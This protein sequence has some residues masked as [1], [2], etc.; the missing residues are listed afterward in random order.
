VITPDGR[1][2]SVPYFS[3]VHLLHYNAK[4]LEDNGIAGPPTTL[5]DLYSQCEQLKAAGIAAPYAAYWT[6]QFVEEYLIL[7]L[8]A[9]GIVPFDADGNP[10]FQDDPKTIDVF[11][12]WQSM[13]QDGLTSPTILTDDPGAHVIAMAQGNSSFFTLHHYF[14]N[15]VR[16]TDGPEAEN[17]T[18]AYTMPGANGQSLQIGEVVQLGTKD[19]GPRADQAWELLKFY[20]W[21]DA[22]GRYGTFIS[23]AQ[24]AALLAPYPGLFA[25][26]EFRAAFP[27]SYDLDALSSAFE[28]SQVVPARV[29]PWYASFQTKVGDRIH[30]LLLGDAS[31]EETASRLADDAKEFAENEG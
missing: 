28:A 23:W 5:S 31:P 10:V 26:E 19:A 30:E 14:L 2:I 3:A 22:D 6:K 12:W 9:E 25:D 21:K 27:E 16:N 13:Y 15:E 1:I 29:L 7:Y 11:S 8:V 18:L 4:Q 20:G 24:A 17:V